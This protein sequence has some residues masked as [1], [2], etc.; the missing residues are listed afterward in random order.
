[1]ISRQTPAASSLRDRILNAGSWGAVGYI[2]SQCLRVVSSLVLTRLLTPDLFGLMAIATL[3]QTIL[4]LLSDVGL[5][6]AVI[7]N[8]RGTDPEFLSTVWVMQVVRSAFIW[9][10]SS[11]V[12]VGLW[13]LTTFDLIPDQSVYADPKLPML[14]F[15]TG[16]VSMLES[17]HSVKVLE[18]QRLM[19]LRQLTIVDLISSLAGL[20]VTIIYATFSRT[21]WSIVAGGFALAIVR[22]ILSHKALP[23]TDV[24][25]RWDPKTAREIARFGRW[26]ILSSTLSI[27]AANADRLLL[28]SWVSPD[29]L[30]YYSIAQSLIGVAVGAGESVASTVIFP[31]LSDSAREGV[32]RFRSIHSR[33]ELPTNTIY[34]LAS[35]FIFGVAEWVV[36][37]LYDP[38]Y[39]MAGPMLKALALS[40][41]LARLTFASNAYVARGKVQYNSVIQGVNL[42]FTWTLIPALYFWSGLE[43]AIYG[44]AL[45]TLPTL[46]LV[47]FFNA[48]LGIG[49]LRGELLPWLAWPIGVA[50][51]LAVEAAGA[52]IR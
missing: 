46:P 11:L 50:G 34:F 36:R 42:V 27:M 19:S 8:P 44:I 35:G 9:V 48:R 33:F 43:A 45:R 51:G 10:V 22:V 21:I 6:Q 7:Q 40:L 32:E 47:Y 12:G 23:G 39:A 49:S 20:V 18:Q 31:A 15:A 38:R 14:L 37:L 25:F 3:V 30:G 26:I 24:P 4:G 52:W 2:G 5:R 28:A 17:F 1:M 13:A 29:V 41:V 16:A